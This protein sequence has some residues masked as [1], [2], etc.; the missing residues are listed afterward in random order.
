MVYCVFGKWDFHEGAGV[1]GGR[2]EC[3]G[4]CEGREF[5]REGEKRYGGD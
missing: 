1:G 5:E 4:W 3:E 2:D